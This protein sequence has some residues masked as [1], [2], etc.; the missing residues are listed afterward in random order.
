M[1]I[2]IA[3]D[4]FKGS[5]SS[6][7]VGEAITE[8]IHKVFPEA[9]S[10][11]LPMADGGEGT[12]EALVQARQGK[13]LKTKVTSPLGESIESFL[14]QLPDGMVVLEMA[15]ASG[16]PLVPAE[17]RNP[18]VTTTKGTGELIL[19]AMDLGARDIILGIGGSATNDGGAGMAQA[20]GVKLLD[21]EGRELKPGGGELVRLASID[22]TQV[23]PRLKNTKITVMC[24]VDNPLCGPRGASAVFGPQKGASS[25]MVQILDRNLEHYAQIIKE[26]LGLDLKDIPGSGAAGGIGAGL[27]AFTNAE[28]KTGVE[29][30]LDTVKFDQM[31]EEAD[32][33]ITGEGRIDSQSLYGKVPMGVVKR[34]VKQAKPVLAIVG[35]IGPGAEALYDYGLSSIVSIVNGPMMLETSIEQAYEL[36][37]GATERAFRILQISL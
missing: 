26:Q 1:H 30:I 18:L 8:G 29:T 31:Q 7:Q 9:T 35:S 13:I 22:L 20:L 6:Q 10:Y 16:L 19:K 32:L 23:D 12:V 14:G 21:K 4:S 3:V 28:L 25:E 5:L 27:L 15:A 34:A 24:D 33:I 17:L 37:I 36:T 11:I 2:L